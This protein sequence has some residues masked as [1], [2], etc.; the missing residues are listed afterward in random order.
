MAQSDHR[1][2]RE[3]S[4]AKRRAEPHPAV[5]ALARLLARQA[6]REALTASRIEQENQDNDDED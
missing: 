5:V 2:E 6:A 4:P 3:T 1:A